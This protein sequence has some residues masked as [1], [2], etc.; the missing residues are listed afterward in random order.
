MAEIVTA[1]DVLRS[2]RVANRELTAVLAWIKKHPEAART[3]REPAE[4]LLGMIDEISPE[5][6]TDA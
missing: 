6:T 4:R 1:S 2:L 5:A 3:L